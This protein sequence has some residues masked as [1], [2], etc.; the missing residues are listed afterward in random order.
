MTR[1]YKGVQERI[2]T[3]L[4]S[5]TV[6]PESTQLT[7]SVNGSSQTFGCYRHSI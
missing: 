2:I 1:V 7:P 3:D 5:T 4:P 6:D